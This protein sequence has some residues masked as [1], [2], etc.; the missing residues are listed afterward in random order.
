MAGWGQMRRRNINTPLT[1]EHVMAS[2]ALPL[3]F[4]PIQIDEDWYGDGGIRLV[5]P[6]A[7]ALL[8][9]ANRILAISNHYV[10][11]EAASFVR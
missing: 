6:L 4:P 9:G 3:F 7:P 5:S 2:A 8:L 1:V 11:G 10:G